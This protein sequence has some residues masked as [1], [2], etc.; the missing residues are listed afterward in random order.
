M[1]SDAKRLKRD[2]YQFHRAKPIIPLPVEGS[3]LPSKSERTTP[4]CFTVERVDN[5]PI[6][7]QLTKD[8]AEEYSILHR[9]HFSLY[10]PPA[11]RFFGNTFVG[12]AF[13]ASSVIQEEPG[14]S[15]TFFSLYVSLILFIYFH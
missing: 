15:G 6:P 8:I 4:Y 11:R 7:A 5:I 3:D 9:F 12:G 1:T 14:I 2:W 13:P 10:H